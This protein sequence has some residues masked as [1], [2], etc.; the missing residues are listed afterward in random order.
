MSF[1]LIGITPDT[2]S[3][4][5]WSLL[6]DLFGAGLSY[7]YVRQ[8]ATDHLRQQLT[9]TLVQ[10]FQNRILLSFDLPGNGM[11][12]HWKEA[13]RL[14]AQ[15]S[16]RAFSTSIHSLSDWPT[17][18]GRVELVFY[19]PVFASISKPGYGPTQSLS[20]IAQQIE[21]IRQETVNLPR[22]IGLG[23]IQ[24]DNIRQ[25]NEAGFDGAAILGTLWQSPDPVS[26]VQELLRGVR[27][28]QTDGPGLPR[29]DQRC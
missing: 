25:V 10:P 6:P 16:E 2:L 28:D 20:E 18:A 9:D 29:R 13:D 12:R 17:L 23:G 15:A 11:N 8:T 4:E 3:A 5:Q 1:Q 14:S 21:R 27:V 26:V 19:S 7:L 22:L 24:A